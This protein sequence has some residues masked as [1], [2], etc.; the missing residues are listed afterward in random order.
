MKIMIYLVREVDGVNVAYNDSIYL[1][2]K[3]AETHFSTASRHKGYITM[4]IKVYGVDYN[5]VVNDGLNISLGVY[6]KYE[7]IKQK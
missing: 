1:K 4:L 3:D 5:E 7:V 2:R 6:E